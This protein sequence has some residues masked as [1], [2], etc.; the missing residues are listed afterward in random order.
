MQKA[1]SA[2]TGVFTGMGSV[3]KGM[4][5][6]VFGPREP[7]QSTTIGAG[8]SAGRRRRNRKNKTKKQAGRRRGSRKSSRRS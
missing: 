1:S 4:Y 5:N 2:V 7:Q 3:A 8:Q 6:S